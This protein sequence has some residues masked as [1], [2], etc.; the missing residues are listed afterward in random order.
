LR[1]FGTTTADCCMMRLHI[2]KH[3]RN[4]KALQRQ[5]PE[6]N[7]KGIPFSFVWRGKAVG[8][9]ESK[10]KCVPCGIIYPSRHKNKR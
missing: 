2:R 3:A 10:P 4:N 1:I 6:S 8:M 5:Q 7:S 9:D